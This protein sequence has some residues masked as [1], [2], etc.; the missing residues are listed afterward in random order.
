MQERILIG[1]RNVR[2]GILNKRERNSS[3]RPIAFSFKTSKSRNLSNHGS[4]SS[5]L[6]KNRQDF[7]PSRKT[8]LEH[9]NNDSNVEKKPGN[10]TQRKRLTKLHTKAL[11]EH[12]TNLSEYQNDH[13]AAIV[14][15]L[16][17]RYMFNVCFL[18]VLYKDIE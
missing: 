15:L 13:K 17:V 18:N 4:R 12:G 6:S 16:R 1:K 7:A 10:H 14:V 8:I 5:S 2:K 9:K 3:T 11:S